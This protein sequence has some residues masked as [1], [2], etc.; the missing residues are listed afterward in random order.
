MYREG[1]E[2]DGEIRL[3]KRKLFEINN[4]S[5]AATINETDLEIYRNEGI[6]IDKDTLCKIAAIR[7]MSKM[8]NVYLEAILSNIH[9]I[10]GT[11]YERM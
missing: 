9:D 3:N 8:L 4:E 5:F 11:L 10:D 2:K 6:I 1:I 7:E